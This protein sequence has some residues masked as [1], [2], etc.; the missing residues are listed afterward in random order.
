VGARSLPARKSTET[1]AEALQALIPYL[2]S[3]LSLLRVLC[4]QTPKRELKSMQ[5]YMG[6]QLR[7]VRLT[8]GGWYTDKYVPAWKKAGRSTMEGMQIAVE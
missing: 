1:F 5:L 2:A 6:G 3:A 4:V 7:A 8:C